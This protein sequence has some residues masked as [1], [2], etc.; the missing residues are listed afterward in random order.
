V[1]DRSTSRRESVST[2][3]TVVEHLDP[4]RG[5]AASQRLAKFV[6]E[7]SLAHACFVGTGVIEDGR[8]KGLE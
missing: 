5:G 2:K 4:D 1:G 7:L 8:I 3:L 6:R